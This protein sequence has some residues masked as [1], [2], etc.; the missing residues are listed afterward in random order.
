MNEPLKIAGMLATWLALMVPL[1]VLVLKRAPRQVD[2]ELSKMVRPPG[3]RL[4][5]A[6]HGWLR[7]QL[8]RRQ[9]WSTNGQSL[10]LVVTAALLFGP[11]ETPFTVE[12]WSALQC[13]I[14]IVFGHS[15]GATLASTR[16]TAVGERRVASLRPR[17]L[18][19]YTRGW[20][21]LLLH[22]HLGVA[23]A[24]GATAVSVSIAGAVAPRTAQFLL[25][26]SFGWLCALALTR[27]CR[28]RILRA[29]PTIDDEDREVAREVL[30]S[31][32]VRD[33][34]RT[35]LLT[36]VVAAMAIVFYLPTLVDGFMP[37]I[38]ILPLYALAGLTALARHNRREDGRPALE[39]Q[40]ATAGRRPA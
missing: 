12:A 21:R 20:E 29:P 13:P 11:R 37:T 15:L 32:A 2:K 19:A 17:T 22:V 6:S 24:T 1:H 3:V 39:W 4:D 30:I 18:D 7:E 31:I 10:M 28:R 8:I 33:L 26:L 16:G 9:R 5:Q 25:V 27:V 36:L 14:A 40:F 23:I 34:L 38:A 35:E